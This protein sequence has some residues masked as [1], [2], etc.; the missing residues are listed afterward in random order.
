E[1]PRIFA[2][3]RDGELSLGALDALLFAESDTPSSGLPTIDLAIIDG[4]ALIETDIGDIGVF[5]EGEGPLDDGF[6]GNLALVAPGLGVEDC[7]AANVTAYGEFSTTGGAPRFKGPL[8][9]RDAACGGADLASAD[10]AADV[11]ADAAFTKVSGD[12]NLASSSWAYAQNTAQDAK[13]SARF[14][15]SQDALTVSH[16]FTF[17]RVE[18]DLASISALR[19]DGTLR[20]GKGF[21]QI[22]WGAEVTGEGVDLASNVETTVAEARDASAG[23]LAEGLLAKLERNLQGTVRGAS[24]TADVT[25]RMEGEAQGLVIPEARLLSGAGESVVALSRLAWGAG[26]ADEAPRLAGNFLTGGT[27]LPEITGRIDQDETG[28]IALRLSMAEYSEGNDRL[29]IPGLQARQTTNG[30]WLFSGKVA[31][32]GAIPGGAIT[33]LEVPLTGAYSSG[34]GLRLGSRCTDMR[35]ASVVYYDLALEE[36][37]LRVCPVGRRAMLIYDG[38]LEIDAQVDGIALTGEL[39]GNDLRLNAARVMLGYPGGF[40]L[41]DL[42]AVIGEPDNAVHLTSAA[43]SGSFDDGLNGTFENAS[44]KLDAVPLD[45]SEMAGRWAYVD[46]ALRVSQVALTLT[47]LRDERARF[48][49]LIARDASLALTGSDIAAQGT[50]RHPQSDARIADLTIRHDLSTAEGNALIDVPDVTFGD[51]LSPEDLTYLAK[52]VIAFTEGSVKGSG[53]IAWT[54]DTIM[55]SGAFR[56]EGLNLAAAFGPVNGLKGEIRFSDLINLT[57]EPSQVITVA[58]INPGIEA[59]GGTV[60]FSL[61]DGQIVQVEDARWPFMGGELVMRPTT[62][63]YGTDE[64]QEYTFVVTDLD[65]AKF[66]AQM[67]LTNISATGTFSG[68][69]PIIFNANGDGR[70]EGGLLRSQAP[71]GNVS[72]I[73]ELTYEDLGAVSNFAFQSLKSL[74]YKAMRVELDG[75]LA[76]EI[77]TRFQIDGVSQGEDASR[78][79]ITRRL[80]KLPI[81]FNINV[82]SENFY[83]LAT[84]VRTFWDP[85]ALPDPV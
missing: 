85:E 57:T 54:G 28:A 9:L 36:Q 30:S 21:A 5:I 8:R 45:L 12:L 71:G 34:S 60:Q 7:R 16:D 22:T 13:G 2:T 4:G 11:S 3:Y 66:I 24:L 67:E 27:G 83:K 74:D 82:R 80:S 49:P 55:S 43:L 46:E 68:T 26:S 10:I 18:T 73:G 38:A 29:A 64:E 50:L 81:R 20:S 15:V 76:G 75:S 23:T 53:E 59:L 14:S 63:R 65:A 51:A 78:N 33:S 25:W 31:A 48:E 37:A 69:V 61:T 44:A 1:S 84:M 40:E 77:I 32:S 62:L 39:G 70:I 58:S 47:E 72:Y 52:G 19:A 35:F 17:G 6:S 56:T 41:A 42:S 79:F